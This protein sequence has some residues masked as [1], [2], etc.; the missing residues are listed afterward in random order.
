MWIWRFLVL[1][2]TAACNLI[3][4]PFSAPIYFCYVAPLAVL[5]ATALISHLRQ[6]PKWAVVGALCFCVLYVVFD[7]TP[8]FIHDMGWLYS[9]DRQVGRLTLPRAGGLR[10][11]P[12]DVRTYE[13][14]N[15]F[16]KGHVRG[17]YIYA[18]PDCPEVYFLNGFLDPTLALSHPDYDPSRRTEN[19]LGA[20]RER[21]VNLI[22]LNGDPEFS[23]P[24][25]IDL[26]TALEREFPNRAAADQFEVRWK[27]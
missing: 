5:S 20:I 15:E 14:L 26:R 16:L 24:V 27:P 1:S 4:F 7:V 23:G 17:Q 10:V 21:D 25:P 22:V 9:P 3:Q 11:Y 18:T 19:I 8:G 12:R 13:V 6:P 2:V